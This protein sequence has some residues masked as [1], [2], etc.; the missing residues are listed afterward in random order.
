MTRP[1][2]GIQACVFDAY[3]TLFDFNAAVAACADTIGDRAD[4]LSEVWRQKQLQYAWLRALMRRHVDFWQI[5]GDALDFA[6]AA[7]G[8]R[9]QGLRRRLMEAYRSLDTF[10][11]VRDVLARLQAAGMRTAILSNGAPKMLDDAVR[12]AQLTKLF[13]AVLSAEDVGVY[14]PDPRVYRL[15]VD[16]LG[17]RAEQICFQSANAWDA[18]GAKAFGFRVVW[19]NRYRQ[20]PEILGAAP[21][22]EVDD[23][24][25]LPA[26]VGL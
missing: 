21:D 10:P 16:R 8:V 3:G 6:L 7:V 1:I 22:A 5:T 12:A 14:K 24:T 20:P 4:R 13:D 23:L 2:A 9:D 15:A 25:P 18:V 17:V 26:L 11:E 19:I